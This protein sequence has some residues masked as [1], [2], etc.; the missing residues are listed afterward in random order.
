MTAVQESSAVPS[1]VAPAAPPEAVAAVAA[2]ASQ[3]VPPT[4]SA[5]KVYADWDELINKA[6]RTDDVLINMLVDGKYEE[7]WVKIEAIGNKAYDQ[8][9]GKHKPTAKQRDEGHIFNPETFPAALISACLARPKLSEEQALALSKSEAWSGGEF[10]GLFV[11]C[12]RLCQ[13]N[14]DLAFSEAD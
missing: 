2:V 12:Q 14:P 9:V 4:A 6:A 10:G 13:G 5:G 1:N 3:P 8:L 7:R 11:R